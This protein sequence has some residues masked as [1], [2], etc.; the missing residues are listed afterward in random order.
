MKSHGCRIER[1]KLGEKIH[2]VAKCL[3]VRLSSITLRV[4]WIFIE[5]NGKRMNQSH[6][7]RVSTRRTNKSQHQQQ[8]QQPF[9]RQGQPKNRTDAIYPHSATQA[10]QCC[11]R[12]IGIKKSQNDLLCL[13]RVLAVV[14]VA[15][16]ARASLCPFPLPIWWCCGRLIAVLD[17]PMWVVI[18]ALL[19]PFTPCT[20]RSPISTWIQ[21]KNT[22]HREQNRNDFGPLPSRVCVCQCVNVW[23]VRT[24]KDGF[25]P[26]Q[27]N[28]SEIFE[29]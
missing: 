27:W 21:I 29:P 7:N 18:I 25:L 26:V 19:V 22:T 9:S 15:D 17:I 1:Q 4:S 28:A 14:I 10:A 11:P 24:N 20:A 13:T 6:P 2:K 12:K 5:W 3:Y 23:M 8:Q 16:A